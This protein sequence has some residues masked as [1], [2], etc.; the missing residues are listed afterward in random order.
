MLTFMKAVGVTPAVNVTLTA[1]GFGLKLADDS[2]KPEAMPTTAPAA[3]LKASCAAAQNGVCGS[4]GAGGLADGVIVSIRTTD[5]TLPASPIAM[6]NPTGKFATMTCVF[7]GSSAK[8]FKDAYAKVLSTNPTRME[9]R[10]LRIHAPNPSLNN[11]IAG[12][13]FVGYTDFP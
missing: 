12:H 7:V 3:D 11:T 1:P 2:V 5:G 8:I 6:P 13:G 9:T 4:A 10:I